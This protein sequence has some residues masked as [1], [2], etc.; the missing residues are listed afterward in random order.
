MKDNLLIL[1]AAVLLALFAFKSGESTAE[2]RHEVEQHQTMQELKDAL[3]SASH[4]I[5][6]LST[7]VQQA[8]NADRDKLREIED[9][10]D[11]DGTHCTVPVERLRS[12][13]AIG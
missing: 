4:A 11:R 5:A 3:Q 10:A 1:I 13:D 6:E 12:L 9:E 2:Q 7:R 8:E